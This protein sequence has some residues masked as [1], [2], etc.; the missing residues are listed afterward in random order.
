VRARV[1]VHRKL[2]EA[3]A[4]VLQL[5]HQLHADH[6]AGPGEL[7]AVEHGASDEPEVAVRVPYPQPKGERDQSMVRPS[8]DAPSEVVGASQLVSLD[9]VGVVGR[10]LQEDPQLG[11]VELPVTIGIE[12]PLLG[13]GR[14]PRQQCA[15]VPAVAFV[16]DHAQPGLF[17]R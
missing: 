4:R 9:D 8:D 3:R 11:R 10:L 16:H 12:H 6:T 2:N 17:R 14:E 7:H 5:A 1:V 13:R 15:A